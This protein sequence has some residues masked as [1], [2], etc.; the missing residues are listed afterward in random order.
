MRRFRLRRD[1]DATGVSGV[2]FVADGV[3][4]SDGTCVIKWTTTTGSIGIYHSAVE[5]IHIHG[6]GGSTV[7]HWIDA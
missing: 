3:E 5:M 1:I 6:H 4:F 2:G 7:I